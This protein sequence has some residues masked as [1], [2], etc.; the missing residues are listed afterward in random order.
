MDKKCGYVAILGIPNVGKSTLTNR[1]VGTK[2][3]IVSPKVQTT[4]R[5]IL[6]V[7]MQENTQIV[8]VDTPG[9]FA[10]QKRLDR[11]MVSAAWNAGAEADV[12]IVLADASQR[13][14]EKTEAILDRALEMNVPVFL[15]FNK[16]DLIPREQLLALIQRLSN[17]RSLEGVFLISAAKGHGVDDLCRAL[18]PLMPLGDWLFPEDQLTDL[19]LRLWAASTLR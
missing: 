10:P 5:R 9:I 12:L 4:R 1:L 2:V 15:I 6:G 19:P 17:Q 14:Q 16:I 11:A 8:L 3:S 13:H 7:C 18:V